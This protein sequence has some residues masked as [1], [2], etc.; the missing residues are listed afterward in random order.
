MPD[1]PNKQTV[2]ELLPQTQRARRRTEKFY[3]GP[4]LSMDCFYKTA[5]QPLHEHPVS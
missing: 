4:Y 1:F 5:S 2:K 3:G